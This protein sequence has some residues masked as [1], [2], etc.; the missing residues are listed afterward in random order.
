MNLLT[1]GNTMTLGRPGCNCAQLLHKA[2]HA[3]TFLNSLLHYTSLRLPPHSPLVLPLATLAIHKSLTATTKFTWHHQTSLYNLNAT[4]LDRKPPSLNAT[5][6]DRNHQSWMPSF[7]VQTWMPPN[8]TVDHH[9]TAYR[10][11]IPCIVLSTCLSPVWDP[12]THPG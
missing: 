1:L 5:E 11:P 7:T 12:A 10:P 3:A 4:E 9:C 6:L 8:L 2:S